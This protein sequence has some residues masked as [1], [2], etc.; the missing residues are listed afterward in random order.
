MNKRKQ[1]GSKIW[2]RKEN[3][4]NVDWINNMKNELENLEGP[5]ENIHLDSLRAAPIK[6]L[7][8]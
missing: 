5:E 7:N 4:S 3:S 8:W 1:V 6:I 2:R